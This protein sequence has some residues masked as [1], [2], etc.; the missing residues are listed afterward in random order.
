M[1]L[2]LLRSPQYHLLLLLRSP[3][4]LEVPLL[5]FRMPRFPLNKPSEKFLGMRIPSDPGSPWHH[6]LLSSRQTL[7]SKDLSTS[8]PFPT[9]VPS[10]ISGLSHSTAALWT[11]GLLV[12]PSRP[13]DL[14]VTSDIEALLWPQ[15]AP[16]LESQSPLSR[17]PKSGPSPRKHLVSGTTSIPQEPL[18]SGPFNTLWAVSGIPDLLP[19]ISNLLGYVSFY[20]WAAS[21]TKDPSWASSSM[22]LPTP[23]RPLTPLTPS[24][25]WKATETC[26]LLSLRK[27]GKIVN[28]FFSGN[29]NHQSIPVLQV[30]R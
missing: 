1:L 3:L 26:P 12:P 19:L 5:P 15:T 21:A 28:Y 14:P 8:V 23:G 30:S 7:M 2:T 18:K 10:P 24:N 22:G 20:S 11:R 9:P 13:H 27:E 16:Y 17:F 29:W 4:Y 25:P 6:R